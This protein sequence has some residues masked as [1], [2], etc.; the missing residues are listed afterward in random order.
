MKR[1][2]AM[3][4]SICAILCTCCNAYKKMLADDEK[5]AAQTA[6]PAEP[7]PAKEL[8]AEE[9]AALAEGQ[10]GGRHQAQRDRRAL[11]PGGLAPGLLVTN[12]L[13][14]VGEGVH[15][16]VLFAAR[17]NGV[18]VDSPAEDCDRERD[19]METRC[20]SLKGSF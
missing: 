20:P 15:F 5:P 18:Q 2:L 17:L 8:T 3:A 10:V 13:D 14:G 1:A 9:K 6:E 19:Q 7:K 16:S 11:V 12:Q 4:L